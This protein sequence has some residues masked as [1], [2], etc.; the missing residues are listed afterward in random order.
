ML[1]ISHRQT[2]TTTTITTH[3]FHD[4]RAG[5]YLFARARAVFW[6]TN[7]SAARVHINFRGTIS[8]SSTAFCHR[9]SLSPSL[10]PPSY[11]S[12][13]RI[14]HRT[15]THTPHK[16]PFVCT[17][18][19]CAN[20]RSNLIAFT[21]LYHD[22]EVLALSLSRRHLGH[23]SRGLMSSALAAGPKR[24]AQQHSACYLRNRIS[25]EQ[26]HRAH[27][28][29]ERSCARMSE[30]KYTLGKGTHTRLIWVGYCANVRACGSLRT[31]HSAPPALLASLH[32][33]CRLVRSDAYY[34]MF[35]SRRR[36]HTL[37]QYA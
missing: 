24:W 19:R 14:Q 37:T 22:R 18:F 23:F 32:S 4:R 10:P 15:H 1:R 20:A 33:C 3:T 29:R 28:A 17:A 26:D 7:R 30:I 6:L 35:A 5:E 9:E 8:E 2:N 13:P 34:Q 36:L 25:V 11:S 31:N 27:C 16:Y 12:S 21:N